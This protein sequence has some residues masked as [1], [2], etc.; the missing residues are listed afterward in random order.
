MKR[1][2]RDNYYTT[3]SDMFIM[4]G[5]TDELLLFCFDRKNRVVIRSLLQEDIKPFV[6]IA[7]I[8]SK[9]KRQKLKVLSEVIPK[10]ESQLYY[11]VIERILGDEYT[12]KEDAI[13]GLPRE[14]IGFAGRCDEEVT[15]TSRIP[16]EV[17]AVM[18]KKDKDIAYPVFELLKK[19]GNYYQCK[20]VVVSFFK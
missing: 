15:L 3:T 11:F 1:N 17:R 5:D 12:G 10:K 18:N 19:I 4:D 13:Y 9:N 16:G 20:N 14:P 8:S 2:E 7:D 6:Q